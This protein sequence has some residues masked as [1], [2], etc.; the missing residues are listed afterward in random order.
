MYLRLKVIKD[1]PAC[2]YLLLTGALN[3]SFF[4]SFQEV[5]TSYSNVSGNY[6]RAATA[7][8]EHY[9]MLQQSEMLPSA[10]DITSV[11]M[12]QSEAAPGLTARH[13]FAQDCWPLARTLVRFKEIRDLGRLNPAWSAFLRPALASEQWELPVQFRNVALLFAGSELNSCLPEAGLGIR[14]SF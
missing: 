4:T 7:A 9:L 13:L 3:G 11:G 2:N 10:A 6:R 8:T 1:A 14:K 5:V 12:W